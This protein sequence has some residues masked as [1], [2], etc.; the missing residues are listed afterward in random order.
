MYKKIDRLP[1]S[2]P[3]QEL[4]QLKDFVSRM[5]RFVQSLPQ[6]PNSVEFTARIDE[7]VQWAVRQ[8][9]SDC[10]D[11]VYRI[12]ENVDTYT[13]TVELINKRDKRCAMT[14]MW[15]DAIGG[16]LWEI[17]ALTIAKAWATINSVNLFSLTPDIQDG[18]TCYYCS[19]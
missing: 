15:R 3:V 7:V 14:A 4:P 6:S 5:H 1:T 13:T 12:S 10:V 8:A 19:E 16:C 17:H 2:S 9:E 11:L 18:K